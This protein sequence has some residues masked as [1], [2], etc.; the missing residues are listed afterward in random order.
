MANLVTTEFKV[1]WSNK[2]PGTIYS[3]DQDCAI[4][5]M[6][7][8][9]SSSYDHIRDTIF[10]FSTLQIQE[11][12]EFHV[13]IQISVHDNYCGGAV[14]TGLFQARILFYSNWIPLDN[15]GVDLTEIK[16]P[17]VI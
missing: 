12:V 17:Q 8:F 1:G 11:Y 14:R 15:L 9:R 13:V 4:N 10:N 5:L 7:R 6:L 2:L 16:Y 3:W